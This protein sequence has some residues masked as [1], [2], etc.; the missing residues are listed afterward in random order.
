[1][2]I[3]TVPNVFAA[4]KRVVTNYNGS[5]DLMMIWESSDKSART[6]KAFSKL[7]YLGS[8]KMLMARHAGRSYSFY[9]L[10]IPKWYVPRFKQEL[11]RLV[12]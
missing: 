1:M 5:K 3:L 10:T 2:S 12:F 11:E 9:V 7:G 8:S 4:N 6:I